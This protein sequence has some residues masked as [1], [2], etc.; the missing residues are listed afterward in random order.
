MIN[1]FTHSLY[2]PIFWAGHIIKLRLTPELW[3]TKM[4]DSYFLMPPCNH[5]SGLVAKHCQQDEQILQSRG[6]RDFVVLVVKVG[7]RGRAPRN[8]WQQ[9]CWQC[10]ACWLTS[11]TTPK[12]KRVL[13]LCIL[14]SKCPPVFTNFT[15]YRIKT[16]PHLL[17]RN[18]IKTK[19]HK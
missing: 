13:Y 6:C 19:Y 5:E 15:E 17:Y 7:E 16:L 3:K 14:V 12:T 1:L 10:T 9:C 8:Q 4:V 2:L 18:T 11:V